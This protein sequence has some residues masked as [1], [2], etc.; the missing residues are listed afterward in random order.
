MILETV[1]KTIRE[2]KLLERN[3]KILVAYSGGVDSTVL[4]HL[5]LELRE[6]WSFELFLAH[7]NHMLRLKAEEDEKFVRRMSREYSLPLFVRREDIRAYARSRALNIE[8]AGRKLRYDFLKKKAR[9][10]GG[11]KVAT[12]HTM[13]DQAETFLMRLLR[14]SGPRGLSGIFPVV[15]GIIVRPL[16]QVKREDIEAYLKKKGL[17]FCI[18]E[19]N[20]DRRYLRNRIRLDL[21]PYIKENFEP[22]IMTRL[23]RIASIIREEDS[24]L[25]RIAKE[26]AQ[27]SIL[28]RD[29]QIYLD[30]KSLSSLSRALRRRIVRDFISMLRGDLRGISF[31]DVESILSLG[32][33]KEFPLKRNIVLR[34]EN[35]QIF[36]KREIP[37]EVRYG[38]SWKREEPL[39][40]KELQWKFEGKRIRRT[41]SLSLDFDDQTR[42]FLDL[43]KLHFPLLVRNRREGD[44]YQPLGAPGKKKLKEIMRAKGFSLSEREKRPVFFSGN[45]IVWILGLPVSEKFKIEAGT[46]DI[47]AIEKL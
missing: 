27:R 38:Y 7:F 20:T 44:R 10:I 12:G 33:G 2:Y 41:D 3:D 13:T 22:K 5:L 1:K 37:H 11:A 24:F 14:G 26:K 40:I 28:K 32:E 25:E 16:I 35:G 39:H 23:S 6:E 19:S 42:A 15:E 8:E 29:N 31:E 30:H 18:D 9:E 47:F 17:E 36:V 34:R 45:E 4:F 43:R 21:L 46:S